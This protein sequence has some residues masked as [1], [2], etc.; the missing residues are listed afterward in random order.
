[1]S[2]D[3]DD[4]MICFE[5]YEEA[6]D[7]VPRI[8]PCSHTL[9]EACVKHL[10]EESTEKRR[11]SPKGRAAAAICCPECRVEHPAPEGTRSFPQNKFILSHIRRKRLDENKQRHPVKKCPK[12]NQDMILFCRDKTCNKTICPQCLLSEHRFHDVEVVDEQK[13]K[14]ELESLVSKID[15]LSQRVHSKRNEILAAKQEADRKKAICVKALKD[16][17]GQNQNFN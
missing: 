11:R 15:S 1:M 3:L 14:A 8:L 16:K 17:K 2:D 6:G 12:H 10:L 9:C 4:C 7:L 5:S 13:D